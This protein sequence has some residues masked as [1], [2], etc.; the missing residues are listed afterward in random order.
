MR[1]ESAL[2]TTAP[3]PVKTARR[4][5]GQR[6]DRLTARPLQTFDR[7]ELRS[8]LA[9]PG[10]QVVYYDA[11]AH[12]TQELHALALAYRVTRECH[13]AQVVRQAWRG[14]KEEDLELVG[15]TY[16][17]D[18]GWSVVEDAANYCGLLP[19]GL[20]LEVFE[21]VSP[22]RYAHAAPRAEECP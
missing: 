21:A 17:P 1:E 4:P 16:S 12:F 3:P 7:F 14:P 22:C 20:A 15:L 5:H 9:A 13:T 6:T 18:V 2:S 10:W 8:L 19:P 11:P